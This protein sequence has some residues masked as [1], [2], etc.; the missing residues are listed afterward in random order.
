MQGQVSI[1]EKLEKFPWKCGW[2]L[3]PAGMSKSLGCLFP[4]PG[5]LLLVKQ[6]GFGHEG[7]VT[8]HV[9]E[10]RER[11]KGTPRETVYVLIKCVH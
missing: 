5:T 6:G 10:A 2:G 3:W 1:P 9:V 7:E 4:T 11:A 8:E